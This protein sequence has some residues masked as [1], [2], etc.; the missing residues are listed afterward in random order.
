MDYAVAKRTTFHAG[1][2]ITTI[3]PNLWLQN[4]VTG[5]I[6]FTFQPVVTAQPTVPVSFSSG[7]VTLPL[8]PAYTTGG[9]LLFASGDSSKVAA[10]TPIDLQRFQRDLAALTPGN[11][12]QLLT[13]PSVA[14]NFRNGYIATHMLAFDQDLG[15]VKL[16]ASYVGT[17]GVHLASVFSPNGYNGASA[18]FAPFTRF[19]SQGQPTGGFGPEVIMSNGSHSSYNALQMSATQNYSAVGL[20]FQASYTFSRSLDDT[21]AVPGGISSAGSTIL[22]T[23][24]QNP[25][26][27]E[28][29]RGLSTFDITHVFTLSLIQSLPIDRI[30]FLRPLS[31]KL[32]R[33]WQF[34]NVTSLMTGSPFSV[35]SGI[36]QTGFGA[37][38]TD[39]PDLLKMPTLSTNRP[40]REDYFG[41]GTNNSSFFFIPINVAAGSG[42]NQGRF[43][44]LGRNTFRGPGFH[45]YDVALIKDTQFGRRGKSELGIVEFRA[46]FFNVFNIVNFGLPTNVVEGSGFGI[47]SKTA[48]PSRQIQLSLKLIY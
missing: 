34:L 18:G 15:T 33:G 9:Q 6:P 45:Q 3:L 5:A 21:S 23:L 37:G 28:G 27:P 16:T 31:G 13:T 46:E 30:A 47:I 22:Q 32:T 44:T 35:Y 14:R 48:G 36:Q 1:G 11:E 25:L 40:A 17:A 12:V 24:A 10:N 42:P 43:G 8:P 26:N 20:N 29:D 39:R 19:D 7:I 38:G 4:Y 41:R 2:A